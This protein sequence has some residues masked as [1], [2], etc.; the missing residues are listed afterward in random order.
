MPAALALAG[1]GAVLLL[2][3]LLLFSALGAHEVADGDEALYG[4]VAREMRA[5]GD[6][7]TPS[8][9][10]RPFLHKP[11]LKYW[12]IG[13]GTALASNELA[14]L[15]LSA[16][17]AAWATVAL[18]LWCARRRGRPLAGLYGSLL[19]LSNHQW[20]FEHGARSGAMD[21]EATFLTTAALL[22][23]LMA[24]AE[25][26]PAPFRAASALAVAL[27]FM[28]KS[29]VALLPLLILLPLLLREGRREA[30]R[31]LGWLALAVALVVFPWHLAQAALHGPAFFRVYVG[32]E[33][34]GRA[35]IMN[36]RF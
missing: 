31:Y 8:F 14:G 15:R 6:W 36:P 34:L 2:A 4:Q 11:P 25:R 27:L 19:L 32:Y 29:V 20:L 23:G 12:L 16:A 1:A 10:D 21:S 30:T 26:R 17:A 5:R 9:W 22:L 7:W 3:A 35:E 28:L 24:P 18:L 33:I 13:V